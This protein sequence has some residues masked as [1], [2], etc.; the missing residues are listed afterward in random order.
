LKTKN[1]LTIVNWLV[2]N[3][4]LILWLCQR[5]TWRLEQTK[6]MVHSK[7]KSPIYLFIPNSITIH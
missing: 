4:Q 3:S 5:S 7:P 2:A 1:L 6:G